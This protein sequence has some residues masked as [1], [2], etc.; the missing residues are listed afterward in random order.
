MDEA[1]SLSDP[2][3]PFNYK[4]SRAPSAFDLTHNFVATLRYSLPLDRVS[5]HFKAL[6]R[7]WAISDITRISTG[8][9]VTLHSD[10]DNS[11]QGSVPNGVNN[12]SID[13]PNY[14]PGNLM[15]NHNPQNG[16]TYFNTSLF[17]ANPLGTPGTAARRFF[18]GP[19]QFNFDMA[20]LRSFAV[21][22]T[23][24]FQFRLETFNTFNHTQFFGPAAVNG[25][26]TSPGFGYIVNA[27]APRLVQAALKFLF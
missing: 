9:P 20:L 23:K 12:F 19:G 15:I 1:S 6:T 5:K 14:T 21:T 4:L 10:G 27:A 24:S 2:V 26:F 25:D 7:G 8:F 22:E 17:S 13:R 16:L 18:Y 3:N 11:L